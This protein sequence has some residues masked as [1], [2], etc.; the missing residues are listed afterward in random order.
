MFAA[1]ELKSYTE[2]VYETSSENSVEKWSQILWKVIR[3]HKTLSQVA[4]LLPCQQ[5]RS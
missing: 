1:C 3:A 4:I 2:G 5:L